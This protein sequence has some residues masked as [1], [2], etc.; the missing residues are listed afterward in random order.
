M[1]QTSTRGYGST[2]GATTREQSVL[3]RMADAERRAGDPTVL[4]ALGDG[5]DLI[6]E[7][8]A[9]RGR[10]HDFAE[11]WDDAGDGFSADPPCPDG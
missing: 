11:A 7:L 4:S 3:T 9:D 1:A 10:R 2:P 8:I 5:L 6:R